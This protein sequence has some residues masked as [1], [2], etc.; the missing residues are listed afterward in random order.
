MSAYIIDIV[1]THYYFYY[2]DT[3]SLH[4]K[5]RNINFF[6]IMAERLNTICGIQYYS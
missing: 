4:F 5:H 6:T 3:S 2:F 1:V